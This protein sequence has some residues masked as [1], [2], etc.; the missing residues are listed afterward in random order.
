MINPSSKGLYVPFS[1]QLKFIIDKY[2]SYNKNKDLYESE[3]LFEGKKELTKCMHGHA[4]GYLR[5]L[6]A[7][8]FNHSCSLSQLIQ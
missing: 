1:T 7:F 4:L 3:Q 6:R 5:H 2:D 8:N